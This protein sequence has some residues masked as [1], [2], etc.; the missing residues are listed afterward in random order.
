M[1][2]FLGIITL[3]ALAANIAVKGIDNAKNNWYVYTMTFLFAVD[4]LI[5]G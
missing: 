1:A 5:R 3:I 2:G 4:Q